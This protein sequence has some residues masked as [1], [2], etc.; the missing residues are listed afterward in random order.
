M[1][2][3]PATTISGGTLELATTGAGGT[4][5]I[6]FNGANLTLQL[7]T[8]PA[9][10]TFANTISNFATGAPSISADLD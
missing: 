5:G 8:V 9:S 2:E 3:E 7:D 4:G 1:G 10:G 6:T